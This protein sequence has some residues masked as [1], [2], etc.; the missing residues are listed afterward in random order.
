[1]RNYLVAAVIGMT[2]LVVH[3]GDV[4]FTKIKLSDVFYSEGSNVGDFNHDGKLDVVSGPYWYE[5]PDFKVKHEYY[6][7]APIDPHGYSKNFFAFV[8][9]FN[10]DGWDDILIIGFPGEGRIGMRT[11]RARRGTG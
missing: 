2:S 10:H 9:D 1:M 11:P 5:G 7:A 6:P 8:D 4:E 3:A